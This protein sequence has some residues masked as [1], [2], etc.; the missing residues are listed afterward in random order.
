MRNRRILKMVL[1]GSSLALEQSCWFKKEPRKATIVI[2]PAPQPGPPPQLPPPPQVAP[3]NQVPLLKGKAEL[4]TLP[5]PASA[6]KPKKVRVA[7]KPVPA[8]GPGAVSPADAGTA[9]AEPPVL[10][11]ISSPAPAP[12]LQPI[13]ATQEV[14]ERSKRIQQYLE[15]A[16]TAVLKAERNKPDSRSKELIGQVRTFIQQAE[17]S[18][19]TDLV[20]AE[21]LAE[22]AEVLARGLK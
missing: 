19:R 3:A 18:R 12:A 8:V 10:P 21:N 11:P 9:A 4:P 17:E 13:L 5:I 20:R 2:P 16:R 22:R 1:L 14:S 6:E 15:R 7:R